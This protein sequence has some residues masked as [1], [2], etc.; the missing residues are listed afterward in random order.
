MMLGKRAK[1]LSDDTIRKLLAYTARTH[2]PDRNRVIVLLSVKAG[3]RAGEI[4]QLTWDMVTDP[5]GAIGSVIALKDRIAKKRGGRV[6][7]VTP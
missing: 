6:I 1:I 5:T 2:H 7:P 3:L 4:A